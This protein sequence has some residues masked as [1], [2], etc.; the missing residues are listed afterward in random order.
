M[1]RGST[2][3][4]SED[5][6]NLRSH[7]SAL[8][9]LAALVLLGCVTPKS[10]L[11]LS[12]SSSSNGITKAIEAEKSV[13]EPVQLTNY[14]PL[15]TEVEEQQLADLPDLRE[16][17]AELEND[18][19][20]PLQQ[21]QSPLQQPESLLEVDQAESEAIPVPLP[22][23][24][25][26][27]L[28]LIDIAA[29]IHSTFPLLR[30]A[31]QERQIA[32]GKQISAWGEFD[33]K[34]KGATENGP[35]G[36]YKTYRNNAGLVQPI[37]SGGEVFGGY[38]IGRGS[39]QP[40]YLERQTNE[41]GE[42]KAG[43]SVPLVRNRQIDARRAELWRA[44]YD[45]RRVEPEI[46]TQLIMFV[47]DGSITYWNWVAAGQR[48]R[49]G[50]QALELATQRNEQIE[51]RVEV[52]DV[53][54]PVFKDNLRSIA[55]RQ[56]KLVDLERKL[57]QSG[58][59]LSLF[60]RSSNGMPLLPKENVVG[61]FPDP[62]REVSIN[63]D[64]NMA[65][66]MS[67]RPELAV[68]DAIIA[69]TNVDLREACNDML[70]QVDAVVVGSQDMGFPSSSKRDKSEFELEAGVFVEVP[71]QRRKARG[72]AIAARRKLV[73]LSAKRQFTQ[74]KIRTE[75]QSSQAA[76]VAAIQKYERAHESKELAEYMAQ[77]ERRRFEL[78]QSNL[79]SV[80]LREQDAIEAAVAEV[81]ALLEYHSAKADYD[82]AMARDWP[83]EE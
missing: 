28:A 61:E 10:D 72:K 83:E 34:L 79:L 58:I 23:Q 12:D 54:P 80:V 29:S 48:Y 64:A 9:C 65:L 60:Y 52:G 19:P 69:R 57:K 67:Q 77:V 50:Q 11:K 74:D 17:T 7:R 41:G 56:A 21:P 81:D 16:E 45:R 47:R 8:I 6:S 37:Y 1:L 53:D 49:I 55:T 14:N 2:V 82:A 76:I 38:R 20:L 51:R 39:F 40:W 30:A 75:L 5:Q 43:V 15:E 44:T 71:I 4:L 42:F 32:M 33:T 24:S 35:L 46:R 3:R 63:W 22:D 66:A 68:L 70:P 18:P 62:V 78:G 31:Y 26:H 36:F 13:E 27:Q 59:K 25:E 73:Q